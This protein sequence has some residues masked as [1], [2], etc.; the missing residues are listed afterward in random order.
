MALQWPNQANDTLGETPRL[1]ALRAESHARDLVRKRIA[2]E[3]HG[4]ST[5]ITSDA[6]THAGS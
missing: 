4:Y 6:T 1:L 5:L 3:M 2:A